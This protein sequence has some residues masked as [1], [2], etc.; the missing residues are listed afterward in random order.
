MIQSGHAVPK[1]IQGL[2]FGQRKMSTTFGDPGMV[3]FR[4]NTS[5]RLKGGLVVECYQCH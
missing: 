5:S 1:S 4:T 2:Q 3:H